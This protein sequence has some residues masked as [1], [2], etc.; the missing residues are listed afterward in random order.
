M[1]DGGLPLL[2]GD[3]TL[4]E[5][6]LRAISLSRAGSHGFYHHKS[7]EP[8][9]AERVYRLAKQ[10]RF[11]FPIAIDYDWQTLRSWWLDSSKTNW[12]SVSFLIYRTGIIQYVHPGGQYVQGDDDHRVL[13][14]KIEQL[15]LEK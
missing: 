6:I 13:K 1:V 5:R 2:L 9:D 15:L 7:N 11:K 14:A 12:T 8:L 10:L 3:R 4:A